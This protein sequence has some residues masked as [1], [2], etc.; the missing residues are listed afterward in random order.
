M[1]RMTEDSAREPSYLVYEMERRAYPLAEDPFTIG[2]D[3]ASGIVIREP[4]VS[5]SHAEVR[6][7]DGEFVLSA[8]GATGTRLNG[9]PVTAPSKLVDG[10]RIEIGSAEITFRQGR[11]PLGVSVVDTASPVNLG[12][13]AMTR[14]STI[15]NPILGGPQAATEKKKKSASST[16][17]LL[18]IMAVV[19]AYYLLL[20]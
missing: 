14:R 6:P 2:R 18:I 11:L 16:L 5:R 17:V 8:T 12:P 9:L 15:T 3:A 7:D 10:D 1:D 20:R 19:A 4:A 13:D